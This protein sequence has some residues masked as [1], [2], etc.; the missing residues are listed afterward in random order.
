MKLQN[1]IVVHSWAIV[2]CLNFEPRLG[3]SFRSAGSVG[4]P[5]Y[6]NSIVADLTR[7]FR[8]TGPNSEHHRPQHP[9]PGA[10]D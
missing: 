2:H 10:G 8:E 5:H 1:A 4:F 9:R 6:P 3:G 7:Q